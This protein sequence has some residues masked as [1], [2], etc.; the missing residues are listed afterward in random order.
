MN[1]GGSFVISILKVSE[2]NKYTNGYE[3]MYNELLA[4]RPVTAS[5]ASLELTR[6]TT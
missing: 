4:G 1:D 5:T 3:L 2:P 6:T